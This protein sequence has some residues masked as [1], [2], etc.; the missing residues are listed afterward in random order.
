MGILTL[1]EAAGRALVRNLS[2][3]ASAENVAIAQ[4]TLAQAGLLGNPSV[5]ISAQ[6][7]RPAAQGMD[8]IGSVLQE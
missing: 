6:W 2:L 7:I 4:A 1:E 5:S 8:I 3:V